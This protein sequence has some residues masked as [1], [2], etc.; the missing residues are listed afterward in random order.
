M[1]LNC[2]REF[3]RKNSSDAQL[4][5]YSLFDQLRYHDTESLIEDKPGQ[6]CRRGWVRLP[7]GW[8]R[9]IEG[10]SVM[11]YDH[12]TKTVNSTSPLANQPASK[13]Q[14]ISLQR[15]PPEGWIKTWDNL[16]RT[17]LSYTPK[18]AAEESRSRNQL[19]AELPSWVPNWDTWSPHDPEPLPDLVDGEKRYWA[20]G[21]GATPLLLSH[22]NL[23]VLA[24]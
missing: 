9:V 12:K 5:V 20:S 4:P 13:P 11:F 19:K 16:G 24:L 22:S 8:E 15:I 18:Q 2:R 14:D 21:S 6:K 3:G 17:D 7:D 10:E 1:V 23:N